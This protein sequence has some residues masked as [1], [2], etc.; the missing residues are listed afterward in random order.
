MLLSASAKI[1]RVVI[2]ALQASEHL[3]GERLCGDAR[4]QHSP[5]Q[6]RPPCFTGCFVE[7]EEDRKWLLPKMWPQ[8]AT[9]RTRHAPVHELA[10][11][12]AVGVRWTMEPYFSM[13]SVE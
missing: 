12:V 10:S 3:Q 7:G 6:V 9:A 4:K 5:E 8:D 1:M 2:C 13:A 11:Y